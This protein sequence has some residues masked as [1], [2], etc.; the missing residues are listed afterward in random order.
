MQKQ[1]PENT[2]TDA[3]IDTEYHDSGESRDRSET[4]EACGVTGIQ[5]VGNHPTNT[6]CHETGVQG[7]TTREHQGSTVQ[8]TC[9]E[10]RGKREND[11]D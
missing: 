2:D 11:T 10:R 3:D 8:N 1:S 6:A 5:H 4:G 9:K 7:M